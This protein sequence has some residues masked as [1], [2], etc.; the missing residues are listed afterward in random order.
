MF[1]VATV[2]PLEGSP[3]CLLARVGGYYSGGCGALQPVVTC[4]L[5]RSL[6]VMLLT[7]GE[8]PGRRFAPHPHMS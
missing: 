8:T 2:Q 5:C 3:K 6:L 7:P 1:V 4:A